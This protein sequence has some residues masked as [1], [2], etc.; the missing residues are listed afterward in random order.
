MRPNFNTKVK[1]SKF[2]RRHARTGMEL[3][4]DKESRYGRP[5]SVRYDVTVVD[6]KNDGS[7]VVRSARQRQ[8]IT[9]FKQV[10]QAPV[11][12][13]DQAIEKLS[14]QQLAQLVTGQGTYVGQTFCRS[15]DTAVTAVQNQQRGPSTTGL[16]TVTRVN[17]E[18]VDRLGFVPVA[19]KIGR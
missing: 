2:A 10:P 16:R 14:K 6:W 9:L 5:K 3:A 8:N 13:R 19:A 12:T 18:L 4:L 15:I 11:L 1:V 17:P 7:V